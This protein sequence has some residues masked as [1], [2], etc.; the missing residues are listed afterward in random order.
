MIM[1]KITKG[2]RMD[3]KEKKEQKQKTVVKGLS[4]RKWEAMKKTWGCIQQC[5]S[6]PQAKWSGS[7]PSLWFLRQ[8]LL[9]HKGEDWEQIT[10]LELW[11]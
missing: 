8:I 3:K 10:E 1:V 6:V 9:L 5:K 2:I 7:T 4:S 11:K